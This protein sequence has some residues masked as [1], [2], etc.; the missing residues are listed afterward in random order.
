LRFIVDAMLPRDLAEFLISD[1]YEASTVKRLKLG[2]DETIW[3][4]AE[5]NNAVVITK[6]SDYLPFPTEHSRAQLIH[7]VGGNMSTTTMIERFRSQLP[8]IVA[9][10][11]AGEKTVEIR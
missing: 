7:F 10:L 9:A 5:N 1:G 6:D 8:Q 4:Y 3:Q 2:P 11:H